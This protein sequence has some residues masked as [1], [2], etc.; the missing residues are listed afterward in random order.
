MDKTFL[1]IVLA[2]VL[3]VL[4]DVFCNARLAAPLFDADV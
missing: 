3:V 4:N 1:I 2:I